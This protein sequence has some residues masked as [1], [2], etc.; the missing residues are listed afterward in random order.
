MKIKTNLIMIIT[1]TVVSKFG[2]ELD[3]AKAFFT[4]KNEAE[5][6]DKSVNIDQLQQLA[7]YVLYLES[8]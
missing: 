5:K 6:L 1:S 3:E 8:F 7:E 4:V 2:W